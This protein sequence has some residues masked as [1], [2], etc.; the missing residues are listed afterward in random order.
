MTFEYDHD[1]LG[2]ISVDCTVRVWQDDVPVGNV[3]ALVIM[4]E[5]NKIDEIELEDGTIFL[6]EAIEPGL[7]SELIE[8]AD[9]ELRN[10]HVV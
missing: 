5:V 7:Y 2:I 10:G 3:S 6:S 4:R 8:A 9:N 1:T